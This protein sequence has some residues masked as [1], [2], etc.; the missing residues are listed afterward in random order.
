LAKLQNYL[1]NA[2]LLRGNHKNIFVSVE[3][4]SEERDFGLTIISLGI[5]LF[6]ICALSV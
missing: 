3:L 1:K 6:P 4:V 2:R 5:I